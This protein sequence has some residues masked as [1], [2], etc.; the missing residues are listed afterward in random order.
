[1]ICRI[2]PHQQ[3][4]SLHEGIIYPDIRTVRIGRRLASDLRR[5]LIETVAQFVDEI[6]GVLDVPQGKWA[7]RCT[8]RDRSLEPRAE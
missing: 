6:E 8:F 3:R 5:Q 1:V 7:R 4:H 2:Q